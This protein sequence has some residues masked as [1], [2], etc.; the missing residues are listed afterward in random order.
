MSKIYR[1]TA[2]SCLLACLGLALT[3]A[4]LNPTPATAQTDDANQVF[5][6]ALYDDMEYR[7]IGTFRGGR[8][9]AEH[10][11]PNKPDTYLMGTTGGGIW[12]TTDGGH[13]WVNISDGDFGGGIGEVTVAP[14]DQS[15]I[16]VGTGSA[17]IRGN[18]S[19]GNGLYKS[20]DGGKTWNFIGLPD[21]GQVG[22]IEV[23]PENPDVAYVAALGSPF[24][25]NEERGV[26]K[27]TDGGDSWDH[28]L[29]INDSTGVVD[30]AMN[31]ERPG[32]VFAAAWS[33]EREPWTLQSGTTWN[34]G[35]G[36]YKTT[37]SGENWTHLEEGLP[38]GETL[39]GKTGITISPADTDRLWAM[40]SAQEPNGGVYRSDDGG[41][42]WTRTN[43]NRKLRQREYY[44][45][46]IFAHPTD[47]NTV[48]GLN[49]DMYKSVDGGKNFDEIDV[50]HGDVHG[51]WINP[52]SPDRMVV[53]N[54]GGGQVSVNGGESWSTYH[55]QPTAEFYRVEVD[56]QRPYNVYGPQQDNSTMRVPSIRKEGE[57]R[58]Q[59]WRAVGGGESGHIAIQSYDPDIVWAG[60]Y[61]G[62]ITRKNMENSHAPNRVGYPEPEVG[63][64][65]KE[66]EYRYQWNAPIEVNP[67]DSSEVFHASQKLLKT[68][69]NGHSW[70]EI[71]RDLTYDDTTKQGPAA[72]PTVMYDRTGVEFYNT[73]FALA[74]SKKNEGEIWVGTDDGRVWLTE[75][76]GGKG[77]W[78]EITP[79]NLPQWSTVN[80]IELS[81]HDEG[82]AYIATYR[83][84]LGDFEPYIYRTEDYGDSWTRIADGSRGIDGEHPTRVVREDPERE[85]L[86]YAGSERGMYVSFDDGDN[87]QEL[88][89][90]L[91]QTPITDLKVHRGD[92]VVATQGRSF[93]IMDNLSPL[94]QVSDE[95]A[96]NDAHFYEPSDAIRWVDVEAPGD[97]STG[98]NQRPEAPPNG[99]VFDYYLAEDA[100]DENP[101]QLE[102]VSPD[103]EVVREYSSAED[104]PEGGGGYFST[105]LNKSIP[106][107]AGHHRV[108]WNFRYPGVTEKPDDVRLW[109]YVGGFNAAPGTYQARFTAN[110][111]TITHSFEVK[112]DPTLQGV[113]D[114][115]LQEQEEFA[116]TVRD[117]LNSLYSHLKL[118]RD[119][120]EQVKS[121]AG[122]AAKAGGPESLQTTADS[123]VATL[124]ELEQKLIQ[125]Q[126][127]SGQ[128]AINYPPKLDSEFS[129]VYGV[130]GEDLPPTEGARQRFQDLLPRWENVRSEIQQVL[131]QEVSSYND[132][133]EQADLRGVI[134]P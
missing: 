6:S 97:G 56:D 53:T 108:T 107:E 31:P 66:F 78:S 44:Y 80:M 116:R 51:L 112:K 17:C 49:T 57:H 95:V 60:S 114:Q 63:V 129:S 85:G 82:T 84:R 43:R 117:T 79:E 94:R 39:I 23:H 128:D 110:G 102:I 100:T 93:W 105:T 11:F 54:D 132:Q 13:H 3:G 61:G 35:G 68:S 38:S 27:T 28:V 19:Q 124:D 24:G 133:L 40:V 73:I 113:T 37:D 2:L 21:A 41:E 65:A 103:G 47:P 90:N 120:R 104:P 130:I 70:Q 92:L 67:F 106:G 71:S 12:K 122:H 55:N 87:W 86:L 18:V 62:V 50:P 121:T 88:Q 123:L 134:V 99:A 69:D 30:L 9:T 81:P 127:E 126:N 98:P 34:G 52:Q 33:T 72:D 42:T 48:Y 131:Q 22:R 14:S 7:M 58:A 64:P 4:A 26:F 46:H 8:A 101:A 74:P 91:P 125:P 89:L 77:N 1:R 29:S 59:S 111:Q 76:G 10:G 16:Y 119:T 109:G 25:K 83:Y 5:D 115:D 45:T 20:E 118:V 75:Q 32:E 36:L 15:V 96:E